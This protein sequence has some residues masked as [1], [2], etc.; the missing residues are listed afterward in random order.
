MDDGYESN[1]SLAMLIADVVYKW[2]LLSS[3]PESLNYASYITQ[4]KGKYNWKLSLLKMR[5]KIPM[6]IMTSQ[7][8]SS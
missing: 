1:W 4:T 8:S 2:K 6:Y 7:I 3:N 5:E